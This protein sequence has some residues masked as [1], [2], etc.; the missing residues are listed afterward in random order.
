MC[1][2]LNLEDS[3]CLDPFSEKGEQKITFKLFALKGIAQKWTLLKNCNEEVFIPF[4]FLKFFSVVILIH[5]RV[6]KHFDIVLQAH[7]HYSLLIFMKSSVT[8]ESSTHLYTV[9]PF[10][11]MAVVSNQHQFQGFYSVWDMI[12]WYMKIFKNPGNC[13][14]YVSGITFQSPHLS[15]GNATSV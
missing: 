1:P 5:S 8:F 15:S 7:T 11:V 13:S 12:M 14:T 4:S 3:N 10:Q 9:D 6:L 2:L